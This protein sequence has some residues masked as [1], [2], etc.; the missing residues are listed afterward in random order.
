MTFNAFFARNHGV[1]TVCSLTITYFAYHALVTLNNPIVTDEL[2]AGSAHSAFP[3]SDWFPRASIRF[4][5]GKSDEQI[6]LPT[7]KT[8]ELEIFRISHKDK[9]LHALVFY[10][11]KQTASTQQ[12]FLRFCIYL[13]HFRILT[14]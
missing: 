5:L 11:N 4:T 2:L 13:F 9:L 14:R 7:K 3:I 6:P 10:V 8:S 1:I 12:M